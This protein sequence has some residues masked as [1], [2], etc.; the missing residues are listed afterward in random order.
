M[1]G[2]I[3]GSIGAAAKGSIGLAQLGG[4][5]LMKVKRP[6]YSI[7]AAAQ[8]AIGTARQMANQTTRPGNEQALTDIN[9]A[10]SGA[11]NNA[12]RTSNSASQILAAS[13]NA[14]SQRMKAINQNNA[15]N[16]QFQFNAKNNLINRLNNFAGYQDKEWQM[17]TFDP[18]MQKAETKAALIGAGLQNFVQSQDDWM[19]AWGGGGGQQGG[20]TPAAV[21]MFMKPQGFGQS[22][23]APQ[24][25]QGFYPQGFNTNSFSYLYNSRGN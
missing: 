17:N 20:A 15:L 24:Y 3:M 4:G 8:E 6:R 11:I 2:N 10:T 7:P 13:G 23:Q 12:K 22:V 1:I 14:N 18:Y 19:A 21:N 16:A 9:R 25:G 5:L